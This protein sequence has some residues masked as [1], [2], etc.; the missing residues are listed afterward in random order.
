MHKAFSAIQKNSIILSFSLL[1][2]TFLVFFPSKN[3]NIDEFDYARNAELILAGELR[4]ECDPTITSQFMVEDY[5]ISKYNI[6]TSLFLIPASLISPQLL[7]LTTLLIAFAGIAVFNYLLKKNQ[8]N[9]AFT[10]LYALFPAFVFFGRT[11]L[12]EMYSATLT[13]ATYA[14]LNKYLESKEHKWGFATGLLIGLTVLVRYTNI[15][16]L[17]ILIGL[18][19]LSERQKIQELLKSSLPIGMGGLPPLILFISINTYLYGA[20]LRSGYYYSG[21][22]GVFITSQLPLFITRFIG[23]LLITYPGMLVLAWYSKHKHKAAILISSVAM[24][25]FYAGFPNSVFEGKVTD[26]ILGAR[27]LIP[28]IPLLL[29]LYADYLNKFQSHKYFKLASITSVLIL[30]AGAVAISA[31]HSNYLLTATPALAL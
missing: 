17:G 25:V 11:L 24:I 4:Q 16:Y 30:A 23:I 2:L 6:G 13:L 10:F 27:F 31:V 15:I 5:C 20:A 12:N 29:L 18:I 28:I 1:L 9:E 19:L 7:P 22:E 14:L 26:I 8:I 3:I 21:E